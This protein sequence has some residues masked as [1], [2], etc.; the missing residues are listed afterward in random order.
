MQ[1]ERARGLRLVILAYIL[2]IAAGVVT[3]IVVPGSALLQAFIADLVATLVIFAFSRY[4][5]NSSFYDPYWSVI[6]PLLAV[7]WMLA[8]AAIGPRAWLMLALICVWA[9]RLT[10]NWL[11]YWSGLD[12]EDWRYPMVKKAYPRLEWLADFGGIHFFP[13]IQVFLGCLPVYA[14]IVYGSGGLIWLDYLAAVVTFGAVMLEMISDRQLYAFLETSQKGEFIRSGLWGWS[15]HPNYLGETLFWVG[16]MLF[17]L[18]AHPAGWWWLILGSL[19]MAGMFIFVSIPM[20][21]RRNIERRPGY[22][23]FMREVPMLVPKPPKR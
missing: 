20:M 18:A 17:G 2:A 23:A 4:Y 3:L 6:P 22:A 13:T 7:Y 21:D 11:S 16:L 9:F 14:A 19:A 8:A 5:R 10:G 1:Q 12:F 15:R